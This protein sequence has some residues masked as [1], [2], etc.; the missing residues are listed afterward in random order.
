LTRPRITR[1]STP[2]GRPHHR[3]VHVDGRPAL[4]VPARMLAELGLEP[5]DEI[6]APLE[7]ELEAADELHRIRARALRLLGIRHRSEEELR[8]SLIRADFSQSAIEEILGILKDDG[9]LDD[10]IFAERFAEQRHRLRGHAPARIESDLR[11][12]GV[13]RDIAH[14]AAW[15]EYGEDTGDIDSS[16]LDEAAM[17]L[18]RKQAHYEGLRSEVARRRM[19]G[20]LGRAG[21]PAR[22]AI[23]AVS[24][25]VEEMQS[26]GLLAKQERDE[27]DS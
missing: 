27:I 11:A 2:R 19:A 16:L 1:I 25:M 4:R 6:A 10:R 22:V 17:L 8:L 21:Y 13:A 18:R 20:L 14:G 9:I 26:E 7:E 15:G 3:V 24:A 23:D 12:R 5:G